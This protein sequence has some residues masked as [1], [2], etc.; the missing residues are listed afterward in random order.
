MFQILAVSACLI[1]LLLI[2]NINRK[3]VQNEK[4]TVTLLRTIERGMFES[5]KRLYDKF[6]QYLPE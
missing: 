6:K 3:V 5:N 4:R 1:M 2:H